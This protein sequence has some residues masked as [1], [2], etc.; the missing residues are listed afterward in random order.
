MPAKKH[1]PRPINLIVDSTF[2][3]K[4]NTMQWGVVVFRDAVKKENLWWRFI[5]EEKLIY[6]KEGL[7]F[8]ER[9][10][11][12]IL[13]T[14][15]DGFSGLIGVFDRYPV[16]FCHFHQKQIMRRYVTKNPRLV[17]PIPFFH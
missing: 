13:S 14:T 11:Y 9:K 1:A 2:F 15:C 5:I 6:Y 8:L 17:E 12:K 7:Q 16:Q 3:G 4:K 10:G